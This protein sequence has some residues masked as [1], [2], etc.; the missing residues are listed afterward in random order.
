MMKRLFP[1]CAWIIAAIVSACYDDEGNYEYSQLAK[2]DI[3]V[4]KDTIYVTQFTTLTLPTNVTVEG[5]TAADYSYSWR[6]WSNEVGGVKKQKTISSEK[7]LEYNITEVPGSYTLLLTCHNNRTLVDSYKSIQMVVQGVITE[8]WMVLHEKE[9]KSDFDLIMTPFFSQR[10]TTDKVLH[11]VYESINGEPLDGKGVKIAS[12]FTSLRYQNV[13]ILTD[14]GGARLD[15]TTM[16]KVY[17]MSTLMPD[18]TDWHPE[19]Y[20]FW[21]YWFSP[22]RYG[23]DALISNGRFY[24]YSCIGSMGFTTYVEPITTEGLTY[25]AAPYAPRYFD[26]FMALVYDELHGRFLYVS[27]NNSG[28]SN[29]WILREMYDTA[30]GN[31]FDMKD[32]HASLRFMDTGFNNLDYGLFE[33]WTTHENYLC[34]FDFD[35]SR[36]NMDKAKYSAIDCPEINDA[37]FFA[38]GDLG[39]VF[40]YAT[41]KDIYLFDYNGTKTGKKLYTVANSA[42]KLTG[43]K[44]LKPCVSTGWNR[45]TSHP[46]NNKVLVLSTYNETTGEGKV[47]M[48][49]VNPSNGTIDMASE[50]VFDGFGKILDMDYNFPKYGS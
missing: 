50:K 17:D 44:L 45:F 36:N 46:Y 11:N 8:G 23:F 2:V 1:I 39:T 14:K 5:G 10:V 24:L 19:G 34:S 41:E 40:Y 26:Y 22:G 28:S 27:K 37:K 6:L 32:M 33:D 9:G 42:E 31:V 15:A 35:N 3:A 4:D 18:M 16:Q 48:Y 25:K 30:S 20:I 12:F 43:M 13:V 38:V 21:H 7:D 49:Y 29:D 47:Y